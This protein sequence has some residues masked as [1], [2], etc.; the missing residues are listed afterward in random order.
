MIKRRRLSRADRRGARKLLRPFDSEMSIPEGPVSFGSASSREVHR[1]E[2]ESGVNKWTEKQMKTLSLTNSAQFFNKDDHFNHHSNQRENN[3]RT[4][5]GEKPYKCSVCSK[6]FSQSSNLKKHTQTHTGEK[7]YKCSVC[8]KGFSQSSNLKK[9]TQTHTGEKPYKCSVC[10]K[11]FSHSSNL[12]KH[13]RTHTGEKPY[14]CSV[15]SKDFSQLSHLNKHT[16]THTGEKPYKCS[17]CSKGFSQ[18][19]TLK[20]HTPTHTGE[21][22]YKCSVDKGR[23]AFNPRCNQRQQKAGSA[24]VFEEQEGE[25]MYFSNTSSTS[26]DENHILESETSSPGPRHNP[27]RPAVQ[28]YFSS[29]DECAGSSQHQLHA[30]NK[31]GFSMQSIVSPKN[32]VKKI[33]RSRSKGRKCASNV[34]QGGD[35]AQ[36]G[37]LFVNMV[38]RPDVDTVNPMIGTPVL[39]HVDCVRTSEMCLHLGPDG[40]PMD[41]HD[42]LGICHIFSF[43]NF[44]S[45][46]LKIPPMKEKGL[47]SVKNNTMWFHILQGML[48]VTILETSYVL[49]LGDTFFVPAGNVYNMKNIGQA[50]ARLCFLQIKNHLILDE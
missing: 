22:P 44:A 7:P 2:Q 49:K 39:V 48:Y 11:G 28:L 16:R 17:V 19:S 41:P 1:D 24:K 33:R 12:K 5:T 45:G 42:N 23:E 18:L 40:N 13:T 20:T 26:M 36:Q 29:E 43:P 50:E 32:Q 3:K 35:A 30:Q 27:K 8:S 46:L 14:K 34:D 6:G 21:K 25:E 38:Q 10:S 4:H 9:H 47:Q 15:C 37:D 31:E